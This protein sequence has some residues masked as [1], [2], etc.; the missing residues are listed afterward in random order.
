MHPN[1][2][3]QQD[4]TVRY[5]CYAYVYT[6]VYDWLIYEPLI[7]LLD[8]AQWQKQY[9]GPPPEAIKE[10]LRTHNVAFIRYDYGYH[11]AG[12]FADGYVVSK[13]GSVGLYFHRLVDCPYWSEDWGAY[14]WK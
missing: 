10:Y 3:L 13:W 6:L 7:W 9:G 14:S 4:P 11:Y 12:Y 2:A 5:N 1:A 8:T